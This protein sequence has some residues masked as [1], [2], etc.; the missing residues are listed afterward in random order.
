[1]G[2]KVIVYLFQYLVFTTS[3]YLPYIL[4]KALWQWIDDFFAMDNQ[5]FVLNMNYAKSVRFHVICNARNIRR[6][7]DIR[8]T[9]ASWSMR[10]FFDDLYA[11]QLAILQPKCHH[12]WIKKT[13]KKCS[14]SQFYATIQEMWTRIDI[15]L[16]ILT[17]YYFLIIL[18]QFQIS[19]KRS[20][21]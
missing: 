12:F 13:Y 1:M 21:I 11:L 18:Q 4:N 5:R 3:C 6:L 16:C 14:F 2:L 19:S 17:I 7:S 9:L 15:Y 8:D 10:N 20:L